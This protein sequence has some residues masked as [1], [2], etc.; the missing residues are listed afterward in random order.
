MVQIDPIHPAS[1]YDITPLCR[2]IGQRFSPKLGSES[3]GGG[4]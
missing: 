4:I 3:D 1:S 2:L